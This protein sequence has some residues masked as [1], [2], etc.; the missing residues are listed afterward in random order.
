[1]INGKM[2]AGAGIP[3]QQLPGSRLVGS[4]VAVLEVATLAAFLYGMMPML[5]DRMPE[6]CL[7]VACMLAA[8]LLHYRAATADPGFLKRGHTE[9]AGAKSAEAGQ[10]DAGVASPQY[11]QGSCYS[12]HL[13]R[14]LRSKHCITCD[15][16]V[17]RF[18]HHCPAICNCVGKGNQRAYTAWMA[19]LLL[20]Q[21]LFLHLSC[22]FCA[23]VAR[24][25]WN[26]AGQHDRGG[27]L[28]L[29]PSLWLVFKLHPGKVLLIVIEIP[30]VMVMAFLVA[31]QAVCIAG[32]LTINELLN[33][34]KYGYM[35]RDDDT[36][37]NRF[38]RGPVTNCVQFW[39]SAAV[40]WDDMYHQ[41]RLAVASNSMSLV[42]AM[43]ISG[44]IRYREDF[45]QR[46]DDLR[47]YRQLKREE[48][49]LQKYGM[50]P[51]LP[52]ACCE[53]NTACQVHDMT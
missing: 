10:E 32:N 15:R 53:N 22:L 26:A 8:P 36:F 41:E 4:L 51:Q 45:K 40:A 14:P 11:S 7:L 42:P 24:H 49:L 39:S 3:V 18:D 2:H 9:A 5:P 13:H 27:F 43:S 31:R 52:A 50:A 44:L 16:C 28:D 47:I 1:M 37:Y 29:L 34:H 6:S 35:R 23:R 33:S 17:D 25:H 21:L 19:V 46:M 20:A 12:C 30:L 38:D 48:D